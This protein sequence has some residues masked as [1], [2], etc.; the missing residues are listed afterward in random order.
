MLLTRDWR[1]S[2][3]GGAKARQVGPSYVQA[4]ASCGSRRQ[5]RFDKGAWAVYLPKAGLGIAPFCDLWPIARMKSFFHFF[6]AI[7][8][9]VCIVA[10]V[11]AAVLLAHPS[12][13]VERSNYLDWNY[14]KPELFQKAIIYTKLNTF[15]YSAPDVIQVGDST[16]LHNVIPDVVEQYLGGLKYLNLGS[17][18]NAGVDGHYAIADFMFRRNPGIKA[19]VLYVSLNHLPNGRDAAL[20]GGDAATGGAQRIESAFTAPWSYLNPPSMA[21]RRA[22]TDAVYSRWGTLRRRDSAVFP[23]GGRWGDMQYS[24]RQYKG[25]WPERDARLAGPRL[26]EYWR[27]FCGDDGVR[28]LADTDADYRSEGLFGRAS[29]LQLVARR[30]ADLAA[31]HDAK[32]VMMFQPH[33]C[34]AFDGSYLPARRSDLEMARGS[35]KNFAFEPD[36]VFEPWPEEDFVTYDHLRVGYDIK[37]SERVGRLL[38]HALGISAVPL[39]AIA[40]AGEP[41]LDLHDQKI[42]SILDVSATP[43]GFARAERASVRWCD[44]CDG[45][46]VPSS[47]AGVEIMEGE[48]LGLHAVSTQLTG[49]EA[50]STYFVSAIVKAIGDPILSLEVL[51]ADPSIEPANVHCNLNSLEAIRGVG[52][53]DAGMDDLGD[54]WLRCWIAAVMPR[55]EARLNIAFLDQNE[56]PYYAGG[57]KAGVMLKDLTIQ[58]AHRP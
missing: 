54:G 45:P 32:F 58:L 29:Y 41:P 38:A 33:P 13:F 27:R 51:D 6:K 20:F 36:M 11:E 46:V 24:L 47:P 25:W 2:D 23:I 40:F 19:L 42:R 53:V 5:D 12:S 26:R 44:R 9:S 7:I 14:A 17:I 39:R 3:I 35:Y 1:A 50:G 31:R 34:R 15:A 16:A 43:G 57:G 49:A 37:N 52:A 4:G 10:A 8:L 22:V 48:G 56:H 30:F 18:A 28:R 21:L 55:T